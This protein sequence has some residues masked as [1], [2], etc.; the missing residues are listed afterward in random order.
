MNGLHKWTRTMDS[1]QKE[2][3]FFNL[4]LA[5]LMTQEILNFQ[6]ASFV[7]HS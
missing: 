3:M 1:N 4:F 6:H 5:I 2:K 7:Q